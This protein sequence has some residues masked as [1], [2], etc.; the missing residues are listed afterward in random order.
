[1]KSIGKGMSKRFVVINTAIMAGI[2]LA[3]AIG[4]AESL[5]LDQSVLK[6]VLLRYEEPILLEKAA[7]VRERI[8][9]SPDARHAAPGAMLRR[10][11]AGDQTVLNAILFRQ[12][13]DENYYT[14]V[15]VIQ[16]DRAFDPGVKTGETVR[17]DRGENYLEKGMFGP[18]VD[19]SI[20]TSGMMS[21]RSVY[22]PF[23]VRGRTH[24]VRLAVSAS[25]AM[26]ALDEH[27][28]STARIKRYTLYAIFLAALLML[29]IMSFFAINFSL[30]I[31]GISGSLKK[32][33]SGEMVSGMD[34]HGDGDLEELAESFNCL[35]EEMKE[36]RERG[37]RVVEEERVNAGELFRRGVAD[38]K[39][40]NLEDAIAMFRTLLVFNPSSF[41]SFFNLGV[42][43]A[44][45]REYD[46]SIK[47]F[48]KA[49]AV[50]PSH[51]L[52]SSYI[53]RVER[54]QSEHG[55]N[56]V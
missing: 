41:G 46:V 45:K 11:L 18:V 7:L 35:V 55:Q 19:P 52:T 24:V 1:M 34:T 23:D 9:S 12:S 43:Y 40:G 53:E 20:R 13:Q 8:S 50:N 31:S 14:V 29:V 51:E 17:E 36:L 26:N 37:S 30:L 21:W 54:L 32:V 39:D 25:Q 42:A 49:A 6:S 5:N 15:D 27:E 2:I 33:T 38:L 10:L 3:M 22:F 44:K 28:R 4:F 16:T 47:M 48:R 56:T